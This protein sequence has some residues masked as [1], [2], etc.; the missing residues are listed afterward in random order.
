MEHAAVWHLVS[1]EMWLLKGRANLR[2]IGCIG[3]TCQQG[4]P[5]E[6]RARAQSTSPRG[7]RR[8]KRAMKLRKLGE[9]RSRG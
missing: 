4:Q 1:T 3:P 9:S 6:G 8:V 5:L 2:R 7:W